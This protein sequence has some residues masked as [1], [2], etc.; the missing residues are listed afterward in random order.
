MREGRRRH[1]VGKPA[2]CNL[3]TVTT[4]KEAIRHLF[5]IDV[6]STGNVP[7]M[8]CVYPDYDAPIVRNSAAGR[9][10]AMARW[11]MPTPPKFVEGPRRP[12][13]VSPTCATPCRRIGGGGWVS[14]AVACCCST[15]SPSR[16]TARLAGARRCG[17]RSIQGHTGDLAHPAG[18]GRM[19]DGAG[20]GSVEAAAVAAG[21]HAEDRGTRDES[22]RRSECRGA[23]RSAPLRAIAPLVGVD[24][25]PPIVGGLG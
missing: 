23:R 24:D 4:N 19:A 3:Y 9:E 15:V 16:P 21:C 6:D 22:G 11:G 13:P 10:L 7:A 8:P 25:R 14:R 12:I 2:E 1:S 20:G 18:G 17:S 5:T